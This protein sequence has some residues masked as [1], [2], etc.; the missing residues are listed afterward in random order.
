MISK[1]IRYL[2][3][4]IVACL[5]LFACDNSKQL[6]DLKD[7]VAQLKK[8]TSK[9]S[10][11]PAITIKPAVIAVITPTKNT[12]SPFSESSA[13]STSTDGMTHPL[14][15]YPLTMLAFKGI[16]VDGAVSTAYIIA[17]NNKVYPVKID[18]IIGDHYGRIKSI[19]PDRIEIEEN[20]DK[21]LLSTKR[22]V[23]LQ[24]KD[25]S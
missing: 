19:Y 13:L 21:G 18:D 4:L 7:Y 23:T 1:K 6:Q 12:R 5:T 20:S 16:V 9:P 17:P 3:F 8:S 10:I 11:S 24:L 25:A 2:S 22:I 15:G 14:Q